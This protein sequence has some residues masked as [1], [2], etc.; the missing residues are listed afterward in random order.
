MLRRKKTPGPHATGT[1]KHDF[2]E[3]TAVVPVYMGR[4]ARRAAARMNKKRKRGDGNT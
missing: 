1:G 3:I 4:A 2:R